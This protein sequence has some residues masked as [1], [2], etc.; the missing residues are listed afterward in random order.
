MKRRRVGI[1]RGLITEADN[2]TTSPT[3]AAVFFAVYVVLP[4][5]LIMLSGLA[6][7]DVIVNKHEANVGGVGGG[8][9]AVI[10]SVG[11]FVTG[12]AVVLSQDKKPDAQQTVTTTT[13][14][15]TAAVEIKDGVQVKPST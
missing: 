14:T 11:A 15:T 2:E 10:A 9:A 1:F 7:T 3:F 13:S 4:L 12:M 6:I 5:V 8:I